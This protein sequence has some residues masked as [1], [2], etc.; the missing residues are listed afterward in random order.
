MRSSTPL[1]EVWPAAD[2]D[3]VH[4][5]RWRATRDGDNVRTGSAVTSS[6]AFRAASRHA[7]GLG[8]LSDAEIAER[9]HETRR[10]MGPT[11]DSGATRMPT[12]DEIA[13]VD[14]ALLVAAMREMLD[15]GQM[16]R[17]GHV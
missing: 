8:E 16:L 14:R 4:T 3:R 5:W 15:T 11:A 9:L 1:V 7:N 2:N 12:W 10:R 6:E 17:R 13:E